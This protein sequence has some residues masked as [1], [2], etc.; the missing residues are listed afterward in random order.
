[1]PANSRWDLIR[2]LKPL[3]KLPQLCAGTPEIMKTHAQPDRPGATKRPHS[4][5][6]QHTSCSSVSQRQKCNHPNSLL[7]QLSRFVLFANIH[8]NALI[9]RETLFSSAPVP[10]TQIINPPVEYSPHCDLPHSD[11]RHRSFII[12]CLFSGVEFTA[13]AV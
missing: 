8:A 1:M 5:A 13:V 7:W 9:Q 4:R 3:K 12:S 2:G 11:K 10:I 6:W